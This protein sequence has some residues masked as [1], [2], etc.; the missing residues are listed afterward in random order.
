MEVALERSFE[1]FRLDGD[2]DV[3]QQREAKAHA[4]AVACSF[5]WSAGEVG[6]NGSKVTGAK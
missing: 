3:A 1:S 4:A 6:T 5:G 2:L